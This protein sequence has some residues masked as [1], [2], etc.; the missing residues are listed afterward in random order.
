MQFRLFMD[1]NNSLFSECFYK[2]KNYQE[3]QE[4]LFM[5]INYSQN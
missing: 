4:L 3:N 2:F 5:S 1:K